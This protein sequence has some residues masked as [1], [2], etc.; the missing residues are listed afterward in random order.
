MSV[1]TVVESDSTVIQ[2]TLEATSCRFVIPAI[3]T[4][5]Q[6]VNFKQGFQ[7]ICQKHPELSRAVLDFRN[8][9]FMDSSGIGALVAAKKLA[10]K[11][12]IEL[13]LQNLSEQVLMVLSLAD[14]DKLFVIEQGVEEPN[15]T[16]ATSPEI[17]DPQSTQP[18]VELYSETSTSPTV[19]LPV[20]VEVTNGVEKRKRK[21]ASSR[22]PELFITHPSVRS[23]PKR[24]IDIVGSLVG[25]AIVGVFFVPIV[26]AIKLDSPGPIFF[27]QVRCSRMGRRFKMWKF[28]SMVVDAEAKKHMVENEASGAIFKS[29]NDPRIT[30]V[31]RFLRKTSL[32]ELPQFWNVLQGDMSLVGTRPPT[33]DEVERYEI[34]QWQRL[35][36]KP[37]MTGEWQ[38]NGRSSIKDFE[39]IVRLDLKYQENWSLSYDIQLILKTILVLF[40]KQSGAM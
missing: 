20:L 22:S 18:I 8:T 11:Q 23:V 29:K 9:K 14:L 5:A 7:E 28:R 31:G 30:K 24:A 1:I 35:D 21:V 33:P 4:V 32:D 26:V 37:G 38:V 3:F 40:N 12:R 25:L 36:V 10:Q 34:P 2:P 13:V 16:A 6:A 17:L 39:D 15:E 19:S 27:G